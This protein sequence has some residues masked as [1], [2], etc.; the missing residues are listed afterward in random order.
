M[1]T[2]PVFIAGEWRPSAGGDTFHAVDPSTG[3]NL[4][5]AHPVSGWDDLDAAADAAASAFGET[6]GWPGERFAAFLDAYADRIEA[7]ADGIVAV[8]HAE[9]ALPAKTRLAGGELPRTTGQLRQAAA[10]A[11]TGSW[12]AATIDT[13]NNIRSRFEPLGPVFC[14]GPNNFPFAFNGVSGGDFAAAVAAGCPVLAKAHPSHPGTTKLLA[15]CAA[16]A[17]ADTGMPAGFVQLVYHVTPG[18]GLK[19]IADRRVAAVAYTGSRSA[20]LKIKEAADRAGTPAYLEMS[21]V[22]PVFLLPGALAERGDAVADEFTQ[23]CLMGVGQFCTNPGLVVLPAGDDGEAFAAAVA[24]KFADADAGTLL[25]AA[26]REHLAASVRTL[27]DAGAEV[28][29]GG[30]P[31]ALPAGN[32][33]RY[34]NTLLRVTAGRFLADPDTLQTE[35]FGPASLLV[36]TDDADQRAAVAD[37]LQGSL[38]ACVYSDAAGG[39]DAEYDALAPAL[40]ARA[41]RL[42]NDKMPTGVAVSPA[43]VHGGPHPAAGHPGFTAVGLPAA[44]HRFAKLTCYDAVRP[45]RLPELL[46]NDNPAGAWRLIDGEWTTK[47][48]H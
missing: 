17:A 25:N 24:K 46:R 35:A 27:T 29:T 32:A 19:L 43:M 21:A 13:G 38:T 39:D 8:A 44:I 5:A 11:R 30:D 40:A 47:S 48:L 41:G 22:N 1:P 33:V 26:G 14:V 37:V 4:P 23:S 12:A 31:S 18:D 36:F 34:P 15:E 16:A 28:V 9:T 20:G 7:N 3:E 42:L 10:C 6:R 45:S 2:E